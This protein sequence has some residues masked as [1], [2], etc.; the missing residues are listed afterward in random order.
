MQDSLLKQANRQAAK[1]SCTLGD[2][3][4][5]ALRSRL[6]EDLRFRESLG[7]D[8]SLKTFGRSGLRPGMNLN[9]YAGLSDAMDEL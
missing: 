5:D 8:R 1:E 4:N 9:D 6:V 7:E 3:V 2:I